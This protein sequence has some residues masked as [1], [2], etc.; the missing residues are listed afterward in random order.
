MANDIRAEINRLLEEYA[1]DISLTLTNAANDV[2]KL[3]AKTLR[4]TAPRRTGA[5]AKDFKVK[6]TK[7]S[8]FGG[9]YTVHNAGHYQLTHLLENGH[10]K[11]NGGTVP[12]TPHWEPAEKEAIEEYEKLILEAI[13]K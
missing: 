1:D 5:Y 2:A 12:G 7:K 8:R 11:V 13:K 6:Q 9:T 4:A 10:A 3:T